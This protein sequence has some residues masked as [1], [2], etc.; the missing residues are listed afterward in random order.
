M[1][2]CSCN[3]PDMMC[4]CG[5]Y[6]DPDRNSVLVPDE[7]IE[8]ML[9]S[10]I[11]CALWSSHDNADDNGGEPLDA[12]YGPDDISDKSRAKMRRDCADFIRYNRAD[13]GDKYDQAGHDFWLTRNRHGAGFWDRG[14]GFWPNDGEGLTESAHGFGETSLVI[15][16]D[17]KIHAE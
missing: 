7:A 4:H 6:A 15:G 5:A 10:Y 2:D 17:G 3:Y 16:D 8:T 13:I 12:N 11:E 9:A 14:H 1:I